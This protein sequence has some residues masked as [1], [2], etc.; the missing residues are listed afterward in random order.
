MRHVTVMSLSA[1]VGILALFMVDLI[2]MYF[3]SLL[4]EIELASAIGYAGSILFFTTSVCIGLSIAIGALVS[5][6]V[7]AKNF[8]QAGRYLVNGYA[9]ILVL[10][11][12]FASLIWFTIPVWVDL[13]GAKGRAAELS[14]AYLK[15]MIPSMPVLGLA[16][17]SGAALR[18]VGDARRSMMSTLTG[19]AVNAIFDP[20]FIFGL[21]LGVEGAAI[22]SV[23]ARFSILGMAFYPV[24]KHHR[25]LVP[26]EVRKLSSDLKDFFSIALPAIVTNASTPI[27]TGY[28]TAAMAKFGDSVVAGLSITGRLTPVAFGVVFAVSGAVG[29]IIGQNYGA[30]IFPRVRSTI[31]DSLVF[32]AAYVGVV[33]IVLFIIPHWIGQIFNMDQ[34]AQQIID[35]FCRYIA[36]T[37]I[38]TGATFV[39]NAAFNNLGKPNYSTIVN[40]GKATIGTIPFVYFGGQWFGATG[41]ILGQA[42]GS[43]VFGMLSILWVFAIVR[44]FEKQ[45][46]T[47]SHL[48]TQDGIDR[49]CSLRDTNVAVKQCP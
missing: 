5:R 13:L 48:S 31:R 6:S 40:V 43:S 37:Y 26:F 24:W 33:S 7:G 29:P 45:P 49:R 42:V 36:I 47:Q 4:G 12:A 35:V 41:V 15:I 2:D 1:S 44:Q 46:A 9:V 23:F 27:G 10:T 34:E 25:L 21:N 17:S 3:L 16:M 20:I 18:A 32:V 11:S 14:I 22:A 19:G 30:K 39:G 28:V 8:E 38:L